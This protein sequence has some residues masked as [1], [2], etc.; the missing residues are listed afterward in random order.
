MRLKTILLK[1]ALV[2]VTLVVHSNI[3]QAQVCPENKIDPP[4]K[5]TRS[6]RQDKF[7]Y[8][9]Q[10]PENYR[11]MALRED[12]VMVLDAKTYERMQ[13][14]LKNKVP[15]EFPHAISIYTKP[16][17]SKNRSLT[18]LVKQGDPTAEKF[19]TTKVSNQT[20]VNYNSA[21]LGYN[22]N[23]AFFTPDRRYMITVSVPYEFE[24]N[25][26]GQQVPGK[27]FNESVF[28]TVI[29]TFTFVRE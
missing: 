25:S 10:I 18:D 17:S 8:R 26:R 5:P 13:C 29:S 28:N 19:T 11:V 6:L 14:L 15:T 2:T 12:N 7:N 24:K 16:V 1:A 23:V 20:A 3:V 21:T 4:G 22:K 9:Y 27:I